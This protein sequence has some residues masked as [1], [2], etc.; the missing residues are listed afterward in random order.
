MANLN[1]LL[2]GI[3]SGESVR[4]FRHAS[5]IFV[6]N[7]YELM[8]KQQFLYYVFFEI[9]DNAKQNSILLN[10]TTL[11]QIEAGILVKA[12]D[13][14]KFRMDFKTYNAYN[15]KDYVQ[16]KI[17]YEPILMTLHDDNANVVRDL[18]RA[19]YAYYFRDMD[20]DPQDGQYNAAYEL[21]KYEPRIAENWGYSPAQAS[22][23]QF[24]RS[25]KIYSLSQKQ[26]SLYTLINPKI[27]SFEH[28]RHDYGQAA[29]TMEHTMRVNYETVNYAKG[30]VTA[31]NEPKGMTDRYD[32]QP[33][34]LTPIGGG[35]RSIT[36]QGGLVD[37]FTAAI[38]GLEEG[39][40]GEAA[41]IAL[42]ASRNF[43]GYDFA[44]AAKS[45]LTSGINTALYNAAN[46]G[47][48][49]GVPQ[50]TSPLKVAPGTSNPLA[51]LSP[52]FKGLASSNGEDVGG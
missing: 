39:N 22:S 48:P 45:E 33:S 46:S 34:P 28:G 5:K 25:I 44:A 40:L 26:Y 20:Y 18:W 32:N 15:R 19:Y 1:Y 21:G 11:K 37:D 24:F 10:S 7:N 27:E 38:S 2:Q 36:G 3:G 52:L 13:L 43:K 16:T 6:D 47:G 50:A 4:D 14:P 30:Y 41:M 29:G 23:R 49:I 17:N 51:E 9:S 35:T 8:P 12:I 42:R 31:G